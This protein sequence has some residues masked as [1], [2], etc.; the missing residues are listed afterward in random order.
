MDDHRCKIGL[1]IFLIFNTL[2]F[3]VFN[4]NFWAN[5]DD[6]TADYIEQARFIKEGRGI[7]SFPYGITDPKN[8]IHVPSTLFPP[9]FAFLI[10]AFMLM[11]FRELTAAQLIPILCMLL[12]PFVIYR[13]YRYFFTPANSFVLTIL[14]ATMARTIHYAMHAMTDIPFLL[15][16]LLSLLVAFRAVKFSS[17]KYILLAG[18]LSGYAVLIRNVGYSLV[19]S[20]GLGLILAWYLNIDKRWKNFQLILFYGLG[21]AAVYGPFLM[22]NLFTFGTF[23]PYSMAPSELTFVQNIQYYLWAL[24]TSFL[25]TDQLTKIFILFN[26]VIFAKL[27]ID[28]QKSWRQGNDAQIKLNTIYIFIS[29]S[30]LLLGSFIV[31]LARSKYQWGESINTRHLIQYNWIYLGCYAYIAMETLKKISQPRFRLIFI[32]V[33]LTAF[34]AAQF[35][36][37]IQIIRQIPAKKEKM[38]ALNRVYRQVT[39]RM[40]NQYFVSTSGARMRILTGRPVRQLSSKTTPAQLIDLVTPHQELM[41]FLEK[42]ELNKYPQWQNS[43]DI[44]KNMGLEVAFEDEEVIVMKKAK[45]SSSWKGN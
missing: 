2:A 17:L 25:S 22:Y 45:Q 26:C 4:H 8:P 39:E 30:Y 35:N 6:D 27:C 33:L 29:L 31:I 42:R 28:F 1:I 32:A 13:L 21:V 44:I 23:Q 11:G 36:A 40:T 34:Y 38:A 43:P 12:I 19:G 37:L 20:I 15:F 7:V 18:V 41:L 16:A 9:G 3:S 14:F 24:T 5:W 10:S